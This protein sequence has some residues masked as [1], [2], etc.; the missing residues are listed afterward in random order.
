M[1]YGMRAAF[2]MLRRSVSYLRS[3]RHLRTG[4]A[5]IGR[6]CSVCDHALIESM[7]L[8]SAITVLANLEA[9]AGIHVILSGSGT[10]STYTAPQPLSA[11]EFDERRSTMK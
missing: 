11:A 1:S 3:F 7:G 2:F 4:G 8:G 6:D 5:Q 9:D 10:S